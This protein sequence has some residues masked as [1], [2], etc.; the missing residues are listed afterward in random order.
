M[1]EA[2]VVLEALK[3]MIVEIKDLDPAN[4]PS[5]MMIDDLGLDSLDYVEIQVGVKRK[6]GVALSPSLFERRI[7]TLI[8][9]CEYIASSET[10]HK[11]IQ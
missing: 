7:K 1:P 6:F 11:V 9:L 4:I 5:D 2:C 8:Q 3:E 10:S